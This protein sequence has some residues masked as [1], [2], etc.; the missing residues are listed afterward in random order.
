M[1]EGGKMEM[2]YRSAEMAYRDDGG[3]AGIIEG[4][5][6]PYN[7]WT[8]VKSV[9]EGH[10][11]ERI[12]PGALKKTFAER[13]HRMKVLFHHGLDS[14]GKQ[15]IAKLEEIIDREDGAYYRARLFPSVPPLILDGLRADDYGISIGMVL[16]YRSENNRRPGKS[17]HNP[18]GIEERTVTEAAMREMSVTAFPVYEGTSAGVRS[19]T[20]DV[21]WMQYGDVI[22]RLGA[23]KDPTAL[24]QI[25]RSELQEEAAP[26]HPEPDES[27]PTPEPEEP[28]DEP[29]DEPDEEKELVEAGRAT[30][31]KPKKDWL[32]EEEAR[33]TW[34]IP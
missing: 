34:T 18:D 7:A 26:E 22:P 1:N 23:R 6:V 32:S 15:P 30:Q 8:E 33:P 12:L 31:P 19:V 13:G 21:L 24:L 11:L 4:R 28:Q 16:P 5:M 2:F 10:F 9:F 29:K 20:D 14:L 27:D 25:L 17:E 3:E